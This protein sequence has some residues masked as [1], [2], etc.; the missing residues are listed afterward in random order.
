MKRP[1][2]IGIVALFSLLCSSGCRD[3]QDDEV[4]LRVAALSYAFEHDSNFEDQ[5][6]WIFTI[7]SDLYQNEVLKALSRYPLAKTAVKVEDRDMMRLVDL[8]SGKRVVH[9]TVKINRKTTGEARVEVGC[10]KGRLNGY[11]QILVLKKQ[12]GSWSVISSIPTW[13]S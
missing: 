10:V 5:T 4:A 13:V 7:E 12:S 2:A 3:N 8:N 9:W 1:F 11:G 6:T